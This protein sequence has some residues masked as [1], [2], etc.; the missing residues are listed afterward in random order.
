MQSVT[1]IDAAVARS[2]ATEFVAAQGQAPV[3][4]TARAGRQLE[5][6]VP[7]GDAVVVDRRRE[8][9]PSITT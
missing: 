8:A 4:A 1:V 3:P 9:S 5:G 2:V 7:G 6:R